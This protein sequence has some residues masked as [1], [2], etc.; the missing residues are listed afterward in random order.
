[1]KSIQHFEKIDLKKVI[2]QIFISNAV[3]VC[4]HCHFAAKKITC[5]NKTY[6]KRLSMA[7]SSS[8][9]NTCGSNLLVK[10]T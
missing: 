7:D 1:M 5:T 4:V 9:F 8:L 6:R 10:A 3:T 2:V